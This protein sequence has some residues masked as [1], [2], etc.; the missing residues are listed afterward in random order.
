M[1]QSSFSGVA[2]RFTRN[3]SGNFALVFAATSTVLAMAVGM[4]VNFAQLSAAR[5]NLLNAL[6]SAVVS[7]ARDITTGLIKEK[8]APKSV[9]AFLKA[10]TRDG[11]AFADSL[12]LDDIRLDKIARQV[13]ATA[14]VDVPLAFPV[15]T[16]ASTQR[17]T[18]DSAAVYSDRTIEVAMMLDITGSMSGQKIKDLKTA[19]SNAVETF[20]AGNAGVVPRVRVA[21]VP[22]ADSVN[23]GEL[24]I[25]VYGEKKFTTGE[26]P[27]LDPLVLA[28][29]VAHSNKDT[30]ATDR[31]GSNAYTDASP[32]IAMVNR[33]YRLNYCP[34]AELQPLTTDKAKLLDTIADF[35]ANGYTG[36]GIG[37]Q[38]TRYMLSP[39]W[40]SVLPA[41]STPAPYKQKKSA[42]YAILMTDG[43][44]NTAFADVADEAKVH[45]QDTKSA[46]NARRHC[47]EMKKDGIEIFTIGFK[48]DQPAAKNVLKSCASPDKS[49]VAHY[50]E[51]SSGAELDAA[52]REIA[53]NIERLALVK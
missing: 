7:T 11:I 2:A 46:N 16:T 32:L 8:D 41:S 3:E 30:C 15:F 17:V 4:A 48:L 23:V 18:V 53:A 21:I 13:L 39:D 35:K 40:A 9:L 19:A 47:T 52:F 24:A 20:L 43:E 45:Q 1:A 36:G 14:S 44:F 27:A 22:Y 33:D 51:A 10:N 34:K 6:D 25:G 28:S 12:N 26:P 50:Y 49:A 29:A 38:W 37:V 31:K 42:K 5:S